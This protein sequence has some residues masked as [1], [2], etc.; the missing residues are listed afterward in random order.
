M[1]RSGLFFGI[2]ATCVAA[3][4]A[5]SAATA[6]QWRSY[7]N[8]R[9]GYQVCYPADL[10]RPRP[11]APNGDGRQF[12][13]TGGAT[14]RVW[15]SNALSDTLADAAAL[16]RQAMS[17]R[18]GQVTYA[19]NRPGFYVLSGRQDGQIVYLKAIK[20]GD[21]FATVE[22]RYPAGQA[23]IWNPVAAKVAS[24]LRATSG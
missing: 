6:H 23:A 21:R 7:A 12:V 11:E 18:G 14:V 9:F 13:G 17:E 16:D 15:G 1:V 10:V 19:V 22:L 2:A 24:C 20:A 3:V 5:A 4:G 8:A